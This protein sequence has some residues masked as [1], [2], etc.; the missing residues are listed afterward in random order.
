M[1]L[2]LVILL[3][4]VTSR[5]K[6]KEDRKMILFTDISRLNIGFLRANLSH[7]IQPIKP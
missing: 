5:I 2:S 1:F 4:A 7:Q 3:V 6:E